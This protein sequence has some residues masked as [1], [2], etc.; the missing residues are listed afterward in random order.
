MDGYQPLAN[1]D[2]GT[3]IDHQI[4]SVVSSRSLSS[5]FWQSVKEQQDTLR[6]YILPVSVCVLQ[7][8]GNSFR[9]ILPYWLS[10]RFDWSLR[11][12]GW[13]MMAEVLSTALI[14]AILPRC[15]RHFQRSGSSKDRDLSLAK[16][17]LGL[18]FLGTLL[19]GFRWYRFSGV[20]SLLVLAGGTAFQELYLSYVTAGLQR[21]EIM[22]VYILLATMLLVA[23]SLC[24]WL[25]A[26]LYAICLHLNS[27]WATS[28][29]LWLASLAF[30]ADR[31]LIR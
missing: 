28:I 14:V 29:P 15:F 19:L 2:G 4:P 13:V 30:A 5:S 17:C 7:E 11:E 1:N 23:F 25:I 22:Q 27:P 31:I 21:E 26:G 9:Y 8:A 10:K 3:P 6:C 24:A 12:T 16:M 20:I 18:S